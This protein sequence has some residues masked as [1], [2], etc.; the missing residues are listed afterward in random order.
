MRVRRRVGMDEVTTRLRAA[1]ATFEDFQ[2]PPDGRV[3]RLLD[4]LAD[5][6]TR[7]IPATFAATV[8]V[9]RGG[10]PYTATTTDESVVALDI[11]QYTAGDGPCLT[12]ARGQSAVRPGAEAARER[13]PAFAE[14]AA[15]AGVRSVLSAPLLIDDGPLLGSLNLYGRPPD[16]FS[17]LDEALITLVT[18]AASATFVQARRYLRTQERVDEITVAL[19]S[20]AEIDQAKGVLMAQHSITAEKA[21]AM[22]V[23]RSQRTNTKLRDVARDVLRSVTGSSK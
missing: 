5:T 7:V 16:A 12:A 6:T 20:R 22:L 8:T 11:A 10:A 1:V 3:D 19:T 9:L 17:M 14:A 18:S 13:W 15:R 2:S 4:R 21:F 23:L